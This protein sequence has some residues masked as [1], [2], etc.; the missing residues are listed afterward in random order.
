[1][2]YEEPLISCIVAI[3]NVE[4]Y[5]NQ[6]ID[7]L[8]YQ[9]YANIEIILVDDGSSDGSERICDEYAKSADS[10]IKVIHQKNQGANIARNIGKANAKGEWIYFIDGDD[11]VVSNVFTE[12]KAYL[13]S[14][15]QVIMFSNYRL[16]RN[17]LKRPNHP[18]D[19]INFETEE[20]FYELKLATMDRLGDSK[21]NYKI[22]DAVSIWNKLYKRG[23]LDESNLE[24][25]PGLPKLQDLTF[26]LQVY[27]KLKKAV[28]VR[29]YGY[30]YRVNVQSVSKRYQSDFAKKLN[31]LKVWFDKYMEEYQ[32]D[33]KMQ[34]AYYGRRVTLVRTA[35]VLDVCNRK[36]KKSYRIRKKYFNKVKRIMNVDKFGKYNILKEMPFQEKVMTFSILSNFFMCCD[37]LVKAKSLLYKF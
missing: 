10:R 33:E 27:E 14:D 11:Y 24:F 32:Q 20:Q 17:K 15:N 22:L 23:F 1:M 19:Y 16:E 28:Y 30:V 18:L 25:T 4:K 37:L 6:C 7:S 12:L 35:V 36:N 2:S 9:N 29:H 26:N 31:T 5:L 8:I 13:N 34:K 21:Y 3:Y